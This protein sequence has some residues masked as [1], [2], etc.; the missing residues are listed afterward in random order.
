M[1]GQ[2]NYAS[3]CTFKDAFAAGLS[4]EWNVQLSDELGIL[5]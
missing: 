5:G 2:S 4:R 1:P 3:G